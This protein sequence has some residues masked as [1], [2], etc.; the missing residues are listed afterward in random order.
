MRAS[1]VV[2]IVKSWCGPSWP[3]LEVFLYPRKC[4]AT[5]DGL[6]TRMSGHNDKMAILY[7]LSSHNI[8]G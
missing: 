6:F 3:E 1:F 2:K 4:M 8:Y 5:L 7:R